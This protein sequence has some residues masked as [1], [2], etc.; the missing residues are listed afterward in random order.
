MGY[1]AY[2]KCVQS[3]TNTSY[4]WHVDHVHNIEHLCDD[5]P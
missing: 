4:M 1:M 2:T 5:Y 3:S